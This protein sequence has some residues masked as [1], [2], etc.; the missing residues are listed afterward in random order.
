MEAKDTVMNLN[1]LTEEEEKHLPD[2]A[3]FH[4]IAKAQAEISFK[5][6]ATQ[7]IAKTIKPANELYHKAKQEGIKEVVE[8]VKKNGYDYFGDT[9]LDEQEWQTQLKDWGI[10]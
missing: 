5:M 10:K 1:Q 3:S 2:M 6:G 4:N 7:A 9:V 8:W